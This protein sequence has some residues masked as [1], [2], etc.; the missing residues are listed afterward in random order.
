[1][2][3]SSFILFPDL[4]DLL[5]QSKVN[6]NFFIAY[7]YISKTSYLKVVGIKFSKRVCQIVCDVSRDSIG[8]E[9]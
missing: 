7:K 8:P 4:T 9:R 6:L 2:M 3:S 1:M 5:I